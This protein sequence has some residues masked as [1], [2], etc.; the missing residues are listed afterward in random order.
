VALR[1]SPVAAW[2]AGPDREG[3]PGWGPRWWRTHGRL[4]VVLWALAGILVAADS[5]RDLV[6]RTAGQGLSARYPGLAIQTLK[7][8]L[9]RLLTPSQAVG[10]VAA[11]D[12]SIFRPQVSLAQVRFVLSPRV[13]TSPEFEEP[14]WGGGPRRIVVLR[15]GREPV[16]DFLARG[17]TWPAA[18]LDVVDRLGFALSPRWVIVAGP[19]RL[20]I[21]RMWREYGLRP[22]LAGPRWGLGERP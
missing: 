5:V 9:D 12:R 4:I 21:A 11:P 6:T 8:Q 15:P 1:R 22:V 13:V 20:G 3:W 19:N 16:T 7:P 17:E 2:L 18:L 10:F 14:Y